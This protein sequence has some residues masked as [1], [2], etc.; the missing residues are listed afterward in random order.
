M[1]KRTMMTKN[2]IVCTLTCAPATMYFTNNSAS[3]TTSFFRTLLKGEIVT[4]RIISFTDVTLPIM[5]FNSPP[6]ICTTSPT[7][8]DKT[9]L[10]DSS[11]P[12]DKNDRKRKII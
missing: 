8:N 9:E 10:F 2:I 1:I 5:F 6:T 4:E 11:S 3:T 7:T 12:N